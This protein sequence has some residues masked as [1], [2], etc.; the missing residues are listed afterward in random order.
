VKQK[1]KSISVSRRFYEW[2]RGRATERGESM[3][4]LIE[5]TIAHDLGLPAEEVAPRIP[6]SIPGKA[7]APVR[8]IRNTAPPPWTRR[9]HG[10]CALCTEERG[11][12]VREID[13]RDFFIC[14]VCATG[15]ARLYSFRNRKYDHTVTPF[16]VSGLGGRRRGA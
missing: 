14:D 11:G 10:L 1:R 5:S 9:P 15:A 12:C 8:V 16:C 13:G 2:L 4:G 6:R 3:S 7:A